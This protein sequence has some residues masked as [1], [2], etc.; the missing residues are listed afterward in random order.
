MTM[1]V[2]GVQ[3]VLNTE[4]YLIW[5]P[6]IASL[7]STTSGALILPVEVQNVARMMHEV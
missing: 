6:V 7:R 1:K 5:L 4:K 2:V 3:I